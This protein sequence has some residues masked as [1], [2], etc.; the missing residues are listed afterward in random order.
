MAAN[1]YILLHVDPSKRGEVVKRLRSIPGAFVQEARAP[2]DVVVELE[3]DTSVDIT[4]VVRSKIR[5]IPG[6]ISTT[7]HTEIL[8]IFGQD[9]GGE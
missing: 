9:A 2:T 7:T 3:K 5:S 4:W 8:G 1:A 6:V